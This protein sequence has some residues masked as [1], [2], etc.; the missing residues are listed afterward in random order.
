MA[1][2]IIKKDDIT[3][4]LW[5]YREKLDNVISQLD[6][7]SVKVEALIENT[8]FTGEAADS[9]KSYMSDVHMVLIGSLQMAAQALLDQVG[10]YIG[11]YGEIDSSEEFV[12]NE[13]VIESCREYIREKYAGCYDLGDELENVLNGISDIYYAYK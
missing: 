10:L 9:V 5:E 1:G 8:G 7:L 2:F 3:S 6:T 12:L 13:E 11:G 4:L